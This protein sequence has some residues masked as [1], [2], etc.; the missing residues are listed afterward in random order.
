[1]QFIVRSDYCTV[2]DAGIVPYKVTNYRRIKAFKSVVIVGWGKGKRCEGLT[3][4]IRVSVVIRQKF[5]L[6]SHITN[7]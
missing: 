1:V 7:L 5:H 2:D 6:S 4:S 3:V